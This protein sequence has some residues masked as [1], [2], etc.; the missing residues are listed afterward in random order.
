M[1]IFD[2]H[3]LYEK[4]QIPM[5]PKCFQMLKRFLDSQQL[6]YIW[7]L[8]IQTIEVLML[9]ILN[10]RLVHQGQFGLLRFKSRRKF[11]DLATTQLVTLLKFAQV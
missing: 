5:S 7:K 4:Q 10:P 3:K 11:A 9:K 2:S 8:I 6:E 1:Y